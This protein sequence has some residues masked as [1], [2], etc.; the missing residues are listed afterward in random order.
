MNVYSNDK[1]RI[2]DAGD[3]RYSFSDVIAEREGVLKDIQL[4]DARVWRLCVE[5][6]RKSTPEC[7]VD[8]ADKGW[9]CE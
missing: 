4:K 7:G 2:P 8:D 1:M 3:V 9:R 6:F 5:Q